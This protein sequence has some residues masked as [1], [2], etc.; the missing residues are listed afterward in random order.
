VSDP[1]VE[2]TVNIRVPRMTESTLSFV[3]EC[4]QNALDNS[5]E[6]QRCF[7]SVEIVDVVQVHGM[8]GEGEP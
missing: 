6:M 4:V 3:Q 5:E 1:L 8:Q 7:M 2:V